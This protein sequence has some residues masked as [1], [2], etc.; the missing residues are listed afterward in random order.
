[1]S[2]TKDFL[3]DFS[4]TLASKLESTKGRWDCIFKTW[5]NAN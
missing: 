3:N 2:K 1:M 4:K 5:R